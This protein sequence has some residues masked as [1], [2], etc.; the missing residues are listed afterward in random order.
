MFFVAL[1]HPESAVHC[2]LAVPDAEVALKQETGASLGARFE[3]AD[4]REV[5]RERIVER[6]ET[7]SPSNVRECAV[8]D[9]M[10]DAN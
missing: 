9:G 8:R 1:H 7:T 2:S 3:C 4:D 6:V 10:P 5:E